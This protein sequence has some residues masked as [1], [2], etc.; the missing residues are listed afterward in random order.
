M[1]GAQG[2]FDLK[3]RPF[4]AHPTNLTLDTI[5]KATMGKRWGTERLE[6]ERARGRT[7]SPVNRVSPSYVKKEKERFKKYSLKKENIE[8][9][10]MLN[11]KWYEANREKYLAKRREQRNAARRARVAQER[12]ADRGPRERTGEAKTMMRRLRANKA[13]S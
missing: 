12:V 3:R 6:H 4:Q 8:R 1:W 9:R 10:S 5:Y 11:K 7:K 2:T 13:N